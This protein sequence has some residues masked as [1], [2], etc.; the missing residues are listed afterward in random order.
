[1]HDSAVACMEAMRVAEGILET[2]VD[3]AGSHLMRLECA[4]AGASHGHIPC[5]TF[6]YEKDPQ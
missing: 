5:D 6:L 1:M 2:A 4:G 3:K